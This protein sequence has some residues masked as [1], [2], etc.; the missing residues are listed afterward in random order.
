MEQNLLAQQ[1]FIWHDQ[2][3]NTICMTSR[4]YKLLHRNTHTQANQN[5]TLDVN[6]GGSNWRNADCNQTEKKGKMD[7]FLEINKK[8]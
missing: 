6:E 2:M 8:F 7:F 5:Y 1:W 4:P 3:S